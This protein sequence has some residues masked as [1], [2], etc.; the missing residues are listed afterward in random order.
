MVLAAYNG[1]PNRAG[2]IIRERA[3]LATPSDSLFWALRSHWPR[4]TQEF[5]PKL[6]GAI[7]VRDDQIIAQ[8]YHSAAGQ[9]HAEV[10]ALKQTTASLAGAT[11]YVNLEPCSHYGRTGPCTEKI[12]KTE[13]SRVVVGVQDP[14]PRVNGRGIRQL[15]EAGIQVDVG[16]L[17]KDLIF[18]SVDTYNSVKE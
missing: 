9:P 4:E 18:F 7:I 10:E 1:G 17:E 12:L 13:I 3:P 2:R 11:L 15:R 8:G 16:I 6:V 14:D 5:V